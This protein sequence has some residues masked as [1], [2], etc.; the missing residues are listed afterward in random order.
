MKYVAS[1]DEMARIDDYTINTIGIPQMVLMERAA[2]CVFKFVSERFDR[3]KKVLVVVESGNNGGDGIAVARML[4]EDGYKV[5]IYWINE[6]SKQSEGF[7]QQYNIAKKLNLNFVDEIIDY[8]YDVVIDGIFGVGL[9]RSVHGRHAEAIHIMNDLDAYKI[10]IDIPS[11]IDSYTGFILDTAFK[12]D[13]TITF[14]LMKLGMITGAGF[15]YSGNVIVSS[16]GI[17]AHVIDQ[18]SPRLYTYDEKDVEEKLPARKVDSHKGS[19]GK[20]GIIAGSKNMAGA[21]LFAAESA[22]RMGCGLVKVC[23]TEEN[24]E[25][26]QQRLPEAMLKTYD[27]NDK[28]SIADAVADTLK[29][30][31]V[32]VIGPGLGTSDYAKEVVKLTFE[33]YDKKIIADADALNIL[34]E[35]KEWLKNTNAEVV[36]TPHLMEMSRLS[37]KKT[38]DIKENKYDIAREFAKEYNTVVVLKDSRT[39][40]ADS[41]VHAYVNMTGNNGMATGGSGDVL[42]GI[43]AGLVGQ[44]M[45]IFEATKLGVCMHGLAGKFAAVEKGRYSMIATD[46]VKSITKVLEGYESYDSID[47]N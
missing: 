42:S 27:I 33:N 23:T 47:K 19:Y 8:G 34:S 30:S 21:C 5:D 12:A 13:T 31:D 36:I 4:H 1:G 39:I 38:G 41:D 2:L 45:D 14:E 35:N 20:I 10:A 6:I 17:P 22:Y 25:T 46:I 40:V 24:R 18:I 28:T 9:N 32:I 37:D 43:L 16:I 3:R 7:K 29:W 26:I 44:G 15:E 11:G